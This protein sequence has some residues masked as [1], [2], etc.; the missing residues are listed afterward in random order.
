MCDLAGSFG[1]RVGLEFMRW[2]IGGNLQQAAALVK[3]ANKANGAIL[4][5]R[6]RERDDYDF[7]TRGRFGINERFVGW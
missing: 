1:L 5:H 2:R 3:C 7:R 6:G 4:V